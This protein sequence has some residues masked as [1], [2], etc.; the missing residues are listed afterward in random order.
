M[1]EVTSVL[2]NIG[3]IL[4]NVMICIISIFLLF[5][6]YNL[7]Q[8]KVFKKDYVEY[9][10]YTFFEV[11]TGSMEDTLLVNDYVFVK[12]NEDFE[13]NDIITFRND[14]G[15][16]VTHRIVKL[17]GDSIV[18]KG[19][20]NNSEDNP[21][22]RDDVIGKVIYV[23]KEYG[24]YYRVIT[25]PTVIVIFVILLVLISIFTESDKKEVINDEEKE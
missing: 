23:G 1:K 13:E 12:L 22:N 15:S 5:A 9:F 6:I 3:H 16:I 25:E 24:T 7:V 21:I 2:K 14:E 20:N 4:L 17:Y 19:D 8:M 11:K 18:T 10:G